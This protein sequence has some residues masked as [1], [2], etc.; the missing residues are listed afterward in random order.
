MSRC[1]VDVHVSVRAARGRTRARLAQ[2]RM[3]RLH[4]RRHAQKRKKSCDSSSGCR[5]FSQSRF[6]RDTS[7]IATSRDR[8][9]LFMLVV[10]APDARDLADA[11]EPRAPK[12]SADTRL[13]KAM[14]AIAR[15]FLFRRPGKLGVMGRPPALSRTP[16]SERHLALSGA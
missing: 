3:N 8:S 5:R 16:A 14:S 7:D 11:L 15:H 9:A 13:S 6:R 1:A 4:I 2:N 10:A 12:M